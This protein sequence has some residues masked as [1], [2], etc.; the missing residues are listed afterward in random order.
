MAVETLNNTVVTGSLVVLLEVSSIHCSRSI[1]VVHFSDT[2]RPADVEVVAFIVLGTS[3]S[4]DFLPGFL[5]EWL[6]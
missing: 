2:T 5:K 6:K 3:S 1:R 4:G